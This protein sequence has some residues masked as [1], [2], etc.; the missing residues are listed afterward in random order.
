MA[1]SRDIRRCALQA[2]YQFDAGSADTPET[3][4]ASL[5]QSAGGD[6]VHE[7]GFLHHLGAGDIQLVL[8]F[9]GLNSS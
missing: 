8:P 6:D 5:A 7:Q 4:R 2:L 1:R 9:E 3:V